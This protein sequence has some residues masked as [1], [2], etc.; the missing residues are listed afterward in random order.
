MVTDAI[1]MALAAQKDLFVTDRRRGETSL[2]NLVLRYTF[3][4]RPRLDNV[5]HALIV[6]GKHQALCGYEGSMFLSQA[7]FPV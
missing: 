3:E 6:Q 4:L 1:Q 7:L 2:S 5:H